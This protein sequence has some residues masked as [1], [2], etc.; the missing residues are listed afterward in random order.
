MAALPSCS[1]PRNG[2]PARG[3][4]CRPP[5][6]SPWP[7]SSASTPSLR[8][9]ASSSSVLLPWRVPCSPK[10]HAG[11]LLALLG[12][13]VTGF[14]CGARSLL[15]S[16]ARC[17]SLC[18]PMQSPSQAVPDLASAPSFPPTSPSAL[19]SK[20]PRLTS[21]NSAALALHHTPCSLPCRP[22]PQRR[23]PLLLPWSLSPTS[24]LRFTAPVPC[25]CS[26][27]PCPVLVSVVPCILPHRGIVC[28]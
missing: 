13:P 1:A 6:T 20:S 22:S 25:P 17:P 27:Q 2:L 16:P 24:R 15:C 28:C 3:L 14:F 23:P 7:L 8:A 11:F 4:W 19:V 21:P 12:A 5:P 9:A 18:P 26:T 10:P